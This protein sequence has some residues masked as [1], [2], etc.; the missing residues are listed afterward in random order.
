MLSNL[1]LGGAPNVC[2]GWPAQIGE[3]GRRNGGITSP[4]DCAQLSL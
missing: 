2:L 1:H 4:D 3:L